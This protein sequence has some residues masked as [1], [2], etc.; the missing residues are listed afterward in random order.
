MHV[1]PQDLFTFF[2]LLLFFFSSG[3]R[4]GAL[5]S[6]GCGARFLSPQHKRVTA[7]SSLDGLVIGDEIQSGGGRSLV[8][9]PIY[10]FYIFIILVSAF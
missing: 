8:C 4:Q 5:L 7:A 1:M 2:F 10:G 9:G 3:S 6:R